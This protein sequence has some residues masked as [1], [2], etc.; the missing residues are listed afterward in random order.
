MNGYELT[1]ELRDAFYV[2]PIL[3]VTA[4]DQQEDME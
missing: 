2:Q 1:K 3:M 4:K